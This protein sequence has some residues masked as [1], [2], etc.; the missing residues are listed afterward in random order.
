MTSNYETN[1]QALLTRGL[2]LSGQNPA[3]LQRDGATTLLWTLLGSG[4]SSSVVLENRGTLAYS[5]RYT[6][7]EYVAL[8]A[9]AARYGYTVEEFQKTGA[10]FRSWLLAG[11]PPL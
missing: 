1:W 10:L 7:A 2:E 6:S 9:S 3:A 5:S 11:K 4:G 8:S